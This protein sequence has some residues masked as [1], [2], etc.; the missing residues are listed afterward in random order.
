MG[1]STEERTLLE[2]TSVKGEPAA[3]ASLLCLRFRKAK[4][5]FRV[6]AGGGVN[7]GGGEEGG[8][9]RSSISSKV[10]SERT[11][12]LRRDGLER[13]AAEDSRIAY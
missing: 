2:L 5:G 10:P 3:G 9:V 6:F 11:T 13:T 1:G 8:V 4:V 12:E 7:R